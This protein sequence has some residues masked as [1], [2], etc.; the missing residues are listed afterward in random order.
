[1][2]LEARLLPERDRRAHIYF[3]HR[4]EQSTR[5]QKQTGTKKWLSESQAKAYIGIIT[6]IFVLRELATDRNLLHTL[7]KAAKDCFSGITIL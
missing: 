7:S 4:P 2:L 6:N 5:V 3:A 1:M